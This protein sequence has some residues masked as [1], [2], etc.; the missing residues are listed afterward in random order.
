MY[1]HTAPS[2]GRV[3]IELPLADAFSSGNMELTLGMVARRAGILSQPFTPTMSQVAAYPTSG[4]MRP[5]HF[6]RM[7]S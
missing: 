6:V 4:G 5:R 2:T 7:G 3:D 1:S